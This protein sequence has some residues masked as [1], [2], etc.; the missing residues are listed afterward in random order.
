MLDLKSLKF[1][2]ITKKIPKNTKL[3]ESTR[4][5]L[6]NVGSELKIN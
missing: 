5:I 4:V 1:S 2:K 3:N 6:H